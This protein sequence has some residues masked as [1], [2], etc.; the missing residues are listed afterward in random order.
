MELLDLIENFTLG[1]RRLHLFGDDASRRRGWVTMGPDI[2]ETNLDIQAW[3][4]GMR[5][6]H[7]VKVPQ[8]VEVL[9][10]KSPPANSSAFMDGILPPTPYFG[11]PSSRYRAVSSSE[12]SVPGLTP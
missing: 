4:N 2:P 11:L 6:G 10:P 3:L 1:R 5:G 7:L 12:K 8:E 9:R